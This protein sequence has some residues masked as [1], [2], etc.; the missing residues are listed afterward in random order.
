MGNLCEKG[1]APISIELEVKDVIS[2]CEDNENGTYTLK[3][4][5]KVSGTYK[6]SV[7]I[8]GAHVLGSPTTLN[9]RAGPPEV[10]NCIVV[11]AGLKTALAGQAVS[12]VITCKDLFNNPLSSATVPP[13]LDF[14]LALL[15]PA[16]ENR[17]IR[18]T[19]QTMPFL[20]SW[21]KQGE[22]G[23]TNSSESFEISYTAKEA[24]DFELH[25]WCDPD[26]SGTRVWLTG[27]PFSV[28]VSGQSPS[29]EGSK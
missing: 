27:S 26:G 21:V 28:R 25:V 7:K 17:N 3:W 16:A 4:K 14:G 20:G 10:P 1:G 23:T 18:D 24:G 5:G 2:A 6:T 22:E 19:I 15:L 12:F 11:G 13:G 8:N 29:R 9:M